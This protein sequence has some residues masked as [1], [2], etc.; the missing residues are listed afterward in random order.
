MHFNL[1]ESIRTQV[2]GATK[3]ELTDLIDGRHYVDLWKQE[4]KVLNAE[5]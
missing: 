4:L 5:I 2:F 1:I 3:T